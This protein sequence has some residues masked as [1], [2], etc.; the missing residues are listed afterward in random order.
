[1]WMTKWG[2][3]WKSS[4]KNAFISISSF[5]EFLRPELLRVWWA[6]SSGKVHSKL[7]SGRKT[8]PSLLRD[9]WCTKWSLL[10]EGFDQLMLPSP[11]LKHVFLGE[12][13]VWSLF[14]GSATHHRPAQ[15]P[16]SLPFGCPCCRQLSPKTFHASVS[17][18]N[19]KLQW[20]R[21]GL[22]LRT[23]PRNWMPGKRSVAWPIFVSSENIISR[24]FLCNTSE[25]SPEWRRTLSKSCL[26]N[27]CKMLFLRF[28]FYIPTLISVNF[29]FCPIC[30]KCPWLRAWFS[31]KR[32]ESGIWYQSDT[33]V[34]PWTFWKLLCE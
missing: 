8:F 12:R 22:D 34:L 3:N 27:I 2:W 5:W 10:H 25:W 11:S 24:I 32:L 19:L 15:N 31:L 20:C 14:H 17:S 30:Y 9:C 18:W 28:C 26:L 1:M 6:A 23:I 7:T 4:V 13:C 21:M 16:G 33:H 29:C